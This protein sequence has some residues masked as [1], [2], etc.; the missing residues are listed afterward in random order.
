M[1]L[2]HYF[3]FKSMNTNAAAAAVMLKPD[4]SDVAGILLWIKVGHSQ[5]GCSVFQLGPTGTPFG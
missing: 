3:A 5:S 1:E 2:M 4:C